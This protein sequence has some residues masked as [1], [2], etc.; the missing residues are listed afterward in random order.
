M[1]GKG[2]KVNEGKGRDIRESNGGLEWRVK[3]GK[4][5]EGRKLI[6]GGGEEGE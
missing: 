4:E 1:K 6:L 2:R 3:V 5:R